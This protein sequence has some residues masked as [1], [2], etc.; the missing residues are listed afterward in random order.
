MNASTP[1]HTSRRFLFTA[2]VLALS[3]GACGPVSMTMDGAPDAS[4]TETG[5]GEASIDGGASDD[6]AADDG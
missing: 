1:L 3:L 6:A 2:S 4:S 5:A